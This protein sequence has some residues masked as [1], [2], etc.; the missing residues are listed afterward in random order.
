[1][2]QQKIILNFGIQI[3]QPIQIIH[4]N[5]MDGWGEMYLQFFI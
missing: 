5:Y 3:H 2:N 1:M 4:Y